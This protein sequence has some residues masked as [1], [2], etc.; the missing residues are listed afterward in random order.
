MPGVVPFRRAR[1]ASI[2]LVTSRNGLCST[3]SK[4]QFNREDDG[5]YAA[6]DEP[7]FILFLVFSITSRTSLN[8]A[9][10]PSPTPTKHNHKIPL[11]PS[12]YLIP[13]QDD[14][15]CES[16]YRPAYLEHLMENHIPYC[17]G[18]SR[19]HMECFVTHIHDASMSRTV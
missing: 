13:T 12:D 19:S 1:Y 11:H 6:S 17:V 14:D 15:F 10:L 16:K 2:T 3:S 4:L 7:L 8:F 18:G 5:L 9:N